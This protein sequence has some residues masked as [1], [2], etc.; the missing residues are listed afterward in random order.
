M[1]GHAVDRIIYWSVLGLA[2]AAI[3]MAEAARRIK[4]WDD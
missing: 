4:V 3:L 1:D 2:T